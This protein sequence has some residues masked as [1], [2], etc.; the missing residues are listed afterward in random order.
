MFWLGADAISLSDSNTRHTRSERDLPTVIHAS[1]SKAD[2][3]RKHLQAVSSVFGAYPFS[4]AEIAS[5]TDL[6]PY[7]VRH[8]LHYLILAGEWRSVPL[9]VELAADP[10]ED[11]RRLRRRTVLVEVK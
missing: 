4:N 11:G 2:R 6:T 1:A 7:D 10:A 8:T 5:A 9:P 3:I